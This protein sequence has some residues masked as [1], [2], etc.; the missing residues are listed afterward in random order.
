LKNKY[1]APIV[2]FL[3]GAGLASV[4]VLLSTSPQL[5]ENDLNPPS[6]NTKQ[7]SQAESKKNNQIN[8]QKLIAAKDKQIELLKLKLSNYSDDQSSSNGIASLDENE[9]NISLE[10]RP[11][12]LKV[13][14]FKEFEEEMKESFLNRFKGVILQLKG[15]ELDMFKN[16]FTLSNET[17]EWSSVFESSVTSF[18]TDNNNNGDH[19]IYSLSCK[20]TICRL[21]V[22][23]NNLDSWNS[24]YASM[25]YQPWY[26]SITIQENSDYPGN[27]IYYLQNLNF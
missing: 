10:N 24:L 22:N 6:I 8:Y 14:G 19:F 21:E 25:T 17:N 13:I 5:A 15:H 18:L 1:A 27:I 9:K 23:T 7:L 16:S 2:T 20:T 26:E 4:T 12:N 11:N 3:L